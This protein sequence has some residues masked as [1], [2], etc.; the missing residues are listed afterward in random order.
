MSVSRRLLTRMPFLL[1]AASCNESAHPASSHS[2][3]GNA[4]PTTSPQDPA[5]PQPIVKAATAPARQAQVPA[6]DAAPRSI[7]IASKVLAWRSTLDPSS[8]LILDEVLDAAMRGDAKEIRGIISRK[9]SES[10]FRRDYPTFQDAFQQRD[11]HG[12]TA[13][14]HAAFSGRMDVLRALHG[15]KVLSP[16]WPTG[17]PALNPREF[18]PAHESDRGVT[19]LHL[20]AMEGH[21]DVV[22][23]FAPLASTKRGSGQPSGPIDSRTHNPFSLDRIP[24]DTRRADSTLRDKDGLTAFHYAVLFCRL[25]VAEHLLKYQAASGTKDPGVL[26]PFLPRGRTDAPASLLDFGADVPTVLVAVD[27]NRLQELEWLRKKGARF[28]VVDSEGF[29]L[30]HHAAATQNRAIAEWLMDAAGIPKHLPAKD[31]ERTTPLH[32]A[33]ELGSVSVASLLLDRGCLVDEWDAMQATPLHR[34]ASNGQLLSIELL[35]AKGA[36]VDARA[37]DGC[38]A[39]LSAAQNGQGKALQALRELGASLEA[40]DAFHHTALHHA[41]GRGHGSVVEMLLKLGLSH[42][43]RSNQG[44]TPLHAAA[45]SGR[46]AV[47]ALL[48]RSGAEVNACSEAWGT[49]LDMALLNQEAQ[50]TVSILRQNGGKLSRDL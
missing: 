29:N 20:A 37:V 27:G 32:L 40:R 4:T 17:R 33:A 38:T 12:W 23:L 11:S 41:A 19:A 49:P 13:L 1:L 21:L 39:L 10:Q 30:L 25:D 5:A 16:D 46:S 22:R 3:L 7:G 28:D 45:G 34:A 50:E 8:H 9:D 36:Q 24:E 26:E 44:L 6:L 14:H 48:L 18:K 43:A 42:G 47:V 2:R 31:S 15:L 35:V